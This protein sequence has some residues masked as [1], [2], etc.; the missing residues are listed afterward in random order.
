MKSSSRAPTGAIRKQ[1][2]PRLVGRMFAGEAVLAIMTEVRGAWNAKAKRELGRQPRHR[3]R[4]A[5]SES[6]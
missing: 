3:W 4:T 2:V 6:P 5:F 1:M